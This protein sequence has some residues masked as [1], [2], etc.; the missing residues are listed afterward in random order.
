MEY[1]PEFQKNIYE[2]L[3]ES[4]YWPE[5]QMR[6]FQSQ[7]LAQL[8]KF[9]HDNVPFYKDRLAK[10]L[11]VDGEVN[12]DH[13]HEIP[14]LTRQDLVTHREHLLAPLLPPGHGYVD[15]HLGSGTTG[16]PVI[17]RHNS[18]MPLVSQAAL[19]RGFS[20]HNLDFSKVFCQVG[21]D[22]PQL[23]QWPKGQNLGPW[24]PHWNEQSAAGFAL[25]I[26]PSTSPENIAEY[27][28]RN[29]VSYLSGR[30]NRIL[31]TARASQKNG[32][33]H[34]L[35][36]I[37]TLGE[38]LTED[39]REECLAIFG[40]Q[41]ISI[42]A[43]K[44][45]Y[46]IAHQCSASH[47]YHVNS[48]LLL[49]EILDDK[50][51]PCAVGETGRAIITSF[52]NTSQPFIRYDIGDQIVMGSACSCGCQL[53]LIE[54]IVGRT[55]HLFRFPHGRYVS[56]TLP[57][58]SKKLIA[59]KSWQ[60]AQIEPLRIEV[61]YISDDSH[62]SRDFAAVENLIRTRTDQ[63]VKVGFKQIT[64]LPL[65]PSGKFIEYVCELPPES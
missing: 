60:V 2:M 57:P 56:V 64:A 32:L 36:A 8:L 40:A 7:Q 51:Q 27:I 44:E 50:G 63:N 61:R 25:Q 29:A 9:S 41:I 24:G 39:I 4:Q 49:L 21:R 5:Q 62:N 3:Q 1:D 12:W 15:D 59:A 46:N 38:S 22:D 47:G 6:S 30:P 37:I 55:N 17:S 48:E 20:W 65:T 14:I 16:T 45:V 10:A 23:G 31:S 34:K 13:W 26:N 52:F 35:S 33:N 43:S 28:N 19:Y 53:P 18:L 42:Y 54:K 58:K 11:T